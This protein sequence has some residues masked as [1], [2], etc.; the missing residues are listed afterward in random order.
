MVRSFVQCILLSLALLTIGVS[1]ATW[2]SKVQVWIYPSS[3]T[4]MAKQE[5]QDGRSLYAIKPE[6]F[7][8][9]TD[10]R[11]RW[12]NETNNDPDSCNGYSAQNIATIKANS[13]EQWVTVSAGHPAMVAFFNDNTQKNSAIAIWT[14]FCVQSGF[15]G[16]EL[17][18]EGYG[19]WTPAEYTQFKQ[20]ITQLGNSLHSKSKK[21]MINGPP[22]YSTLSQ[23]WYEWKYEDFGTLPLDYMSVMAYDYMYD[24]GCGTPVQPIDWLEQTIDWTLAKYPFLDRIVMGIPSY[25]YSGNTGSYVVERT[26]KAQATRI[27]GFTGATRDPNSQEMTWTSGG[28]SHFYVDTTALNAK[29]TAIENKGIKHVAV[30]HLGGNDWFTGQEPADIGVPS[31]GSSSSQVPSKTSPPESTGVPATDTTDTSS[32]GQVCCGPC[33]EMGSTTGNSGK[34][35]LIIVIVVVAI[36]GI[37]GIVLGTFMGYRYGKKKSNGHNAGIM[38]PQENVVNVPVHSGPPRVN[39]ESISEPTSPTVL[40]GLQRRQ[41]FTTGIVDSPDLSQLRK[42]HKNL[43]VPGNN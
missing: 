35:S 15:T 20:F 3:V 19:D 1:S 13:K 26:N 40:P 8:I 32:D 33:S 31:T 17:D 6:Y 12:L 28:K 11:W 41:M 36:V 25:G 4:C 10:G 16:V 39:S 14:E 18:W 42:S 5:Y 27:T 30:F 7:T 43:S 37:L 23:G 38:L 21:L 29:R 22:I 9:G 24:H 2:K 34:I